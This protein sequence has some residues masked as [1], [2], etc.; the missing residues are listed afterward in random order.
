MNA[1]LLF[2]SVAGAHFLALLS[3]G[4]D[5][6][7]I[8]RSGLSK[9]WRR[10]LG[11]AFGISASNGVYVALCLVGAASLIAASPLSLD[12]IKLAGGL[13][14]V[15]L[16]IG[17]LR[18]KRTG[19]EV[20]PD[21][22]PE[23]SAACPPGRMPDLGGSFSQEFRT[24]FCASLLNPKLPLFYLSL[25]SLVLDHGVSFSF[26][27]ALGFWMTAVVLAW[28]AFILRV[29]S[30]PLVRGAFLRKVRLVD[31]LTGIMLCAIGARILFSVFFS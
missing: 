6:V 9:P 28:D 18:S 19:E 25:F 13:Y 17:G 21:V 29:L 4:A 30:R 2:L 11:I 10:A 22:S 14:L 24:G 20:C 26:R 5:F 16:G 7:L 1:F 12:A 3:P 23:T 31:R 27:L 8:V 15:W